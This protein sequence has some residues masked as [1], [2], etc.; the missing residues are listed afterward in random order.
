MTTR[1]RFIQW[2]PA[3]GVAVASAH[4]RAQAQAQAPMVDPN[5]PQAKAL[6]YVTDATKVDKSKYPKYQ[7]GQHCAVCQLYQGP[8][9]AQTAPC[10]IFAGKRVVGPGWCSAFVPKTS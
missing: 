1:R 7:S 10:T 4:A 2:V 5:D 9:S 8:A 6:G 3:A